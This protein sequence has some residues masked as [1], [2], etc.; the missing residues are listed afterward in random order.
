MYLDIMGDLVCGQ[1]VG[2]LTERIF[3]FLRYQLQAGYHIEN[4]PRHRH[5]EV[6]H[7]EDISQRKGEH[8]GEDE[9]FD[10]DRIGKRDGS[11]PDPF[12]GAADIGEGL[13]LGIENDELKIEDLEDTL[14]LIPSAEL[15]RARGGFHCMSLPILRDDIT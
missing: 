8:I 10:K 4:K 15:S 3:Y 5:Y 1:V 2:I 11:I 9:F 7:A 13:Q 14:I 12:A 6:A